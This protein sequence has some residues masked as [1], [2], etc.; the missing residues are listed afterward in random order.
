MQNVP[1]KPFGSSTKG[2][3]GNNGIWIE[4]EDFEDKGDWT[5]ET[6]FTHLMGSAYLMAPGVLKPVGAARTPFTVADAGRY[7]VW[8]RTKDWVPE[9]HPGRFRVLVDG[10]RVGGELGA[11]GRVG[12][13]WERAGDVDLA[14]G[15]HELALDDMTGAFARCDAI[16]FAPEGAP[17]PDDDLA[18][19]ERLRARLAPQPPPR[20][21]SF[22]VVVVGAGPAGICAAV[23]AA[24]GGAKTAL[25]QDRPIVGGNCSDE[26]G[27]PASGAST[28][29]HP[30]WDERGIVEE[31]TENRGRYGRR[32]IAA[33]IAKLL[34][35]ERNLAVATDERVVAAETE[36]GR[37]VAA[38]SRNT[39]T[40]ARTHWRGKIFVDCTGDGWLG[41]HAGAEYRIGRE[42][43]SE[44][45]EPEDLAPAVADRLTMSGC[46]PPYEWEMRDRPVRFVTPAW[47]DVLPEGFTRNV[48][49]LT[50]PWWLEHPNDLD[51]LD[52]GEEARD[53]LI[54]YVFAYWG[55]LK[56]ESPLAEKAANAELVRVPAVDGR[57]ES[58]RLVGDFVLSAGDLLAGRMFEDAVAY[59]GWGLDVHDP[60]GMKSPVSNGWGPGTRPREVPIYS[61]PFRCL[62]SRNVPNLLM[63]GRCISATHLALGSTRVG[64]TCAIEGQAA[65]TAAAMCALGGTAPRELGRNRIRELQDRLL[66]DGMRIPGFGEPARRPDG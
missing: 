7:A 6:Q 30:G 54:R 42:A 64:A 21:E 13:T 31:W 11:S 52:G 3:A 33:A 15:T 24:R 23:A 22:D 8:L 66:A 20:E 38:V 57:R 44:F 62:Y 34:A 28:F 1:T 29:G 49:R 10:A 58:R 26:I 65:G 9:H 32:P 61:I 14:R 16:W 50:R 35:G 43:A 63:A 17:A 51:D 40:G 4:A 36:G 39:L 53:E 41:F 5:V 37:I 12:W 18:A 59:G 56:N 19:T 47:A 55:W 48:D 46:L 60:M 25:V 45:D 2:G 27:I